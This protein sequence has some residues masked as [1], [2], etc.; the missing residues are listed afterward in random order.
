MVNVY[1]CFYKNY[2]FVLQISSLNVFEANIIQLVLKR[3]SSIRTSNGHF[4]NENLS[5]ANGMNCTQGCT[6]R[7]LAL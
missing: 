4:V 6:R 7:P 5:I 2:Q 1:K 3:I